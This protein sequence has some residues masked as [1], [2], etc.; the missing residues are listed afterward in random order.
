MKMCIYLPVHIYLYVHVCHMQE[1]DIQAHINCWNG[2][3]TDISAYR[4]IC[5]HMQVIIY[6]CIMIIFVSMQYE[7]CI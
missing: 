5:T 6:V 1:P 7:M 3:H 4:H 2:I